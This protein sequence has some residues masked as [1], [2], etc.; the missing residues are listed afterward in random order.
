LQQSKDVADLKAVS[1]NL[2]HSNLSIT[3]GVYGILSSADVGER[4]AGL[5]GKVASGKA[6]TIE[7]ADQLIQLAEMLKKDGVFPGT[8]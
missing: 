3:D 7:I 8:K 4:I 5:G 1:Q 6:S 2:M